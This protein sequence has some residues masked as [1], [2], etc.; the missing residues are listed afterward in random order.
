M[1][2]MVHHSPADAFRSSTDRRHRN[3]EIARLRPRP[4]SIAVAL[5]LLSLEGSGLALAQ[6]LP[7][8]AN[9]AAG[10]ATFQQPNAHTMVVN[11]SSERAVILYNSFSIGAS[12][13]VVFRQPGASSVAL[14]RV[15]GQDPSLIYGSL[16]A[17]GQVFLVN[18]SGILFGRGASVNVGSLVAS[19]LGISNQ[20]F[21]A[22][23]YLFA[24]GSG[25]GTVVNEATIRAA[26]GGYVALLG[27]QVS[28]TGTLVANRGSVGLG[29]GESMLLDFNGDGLLSVKVN[30]AAAAARIDHTGVIQADGG[31][32]SMS[33]RAKNALLGTVL[34]VEG[35]VMARGLSERNGAIYL[36]GGGSG[37]TSVSGTLDVGTAVTGQRGG[38][39][40][41]LGEYVG[42]FDNAT[43]SA[44]GPAGGGTVLIGGDFQGANPAVSN[45]KGVFVGSA[46]RIAADATEQGDGGK[47]IL[48]SDEAT[49]FHGQVSAR[50]GPNGG[51]GGF[52]EISGKASLAF[53]GK[54]DAR[55]PKGTAGTLLLDPASI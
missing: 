50:G 16:Q 15:V 47:V 19:T 49:K 25:A 41:A 4:V 22:G 45:A 23:R 1:T 36:D 10:A 53:R 32:V 26:D 48:W 34:N 51:D 28:N 31:Q 5:A 21:L 27:K 52:V 24:S 35:I 2:R 13:S 54:V 17:N 40:R 39:I 18:P 14:N 37:V 8:G 11:Q 29:A 3:H 20:D 46:T 7:T 55:A 44:S 12:N 30:A 38:E 33:A 9:V 43:L 6:T 42:L